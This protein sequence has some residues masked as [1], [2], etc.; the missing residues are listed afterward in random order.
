M[1]LASFVPQSTQEPPLLASVQPNTLARTLTGSDLLRWGL[2]LP[3]VDGE[4]EERA[5]VGR[6]GGMI[7]SREPSSTSF[8]GR[9]L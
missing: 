6:A 2:F 8:V 3:P 1:G 7:S 4:E 9:T 5:D